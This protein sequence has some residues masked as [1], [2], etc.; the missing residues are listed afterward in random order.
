MKSIATSEIDMRMAHTEA[1]SVSEGINPESLLMGAIQAKVAPEVIRQL[2]DMRGQLQRELAR[3]AYYR[4]FPLMRA[5]I[6]EPEKTKPVY[7]KDKKTVRFRYAPLSS[8]QNAINAAIAKT[9][10][11]FSYR[12][13]C[14]SQDKDSVTIRCILT[15]AFGHSESSE[16][17]NYIDHSAYMNLG[18]KIAACRTFAKRYTVM[19]VNGLE[20]DEDTDNGATLKHTDEPKPKPQLLSV[21]ELNAAKL[22]L[23]QAD[24]IQGAWRRIARQVLDRNDN[25]AHAEL[26]NFTTQLVEQRKTAEANAKA[27]S[28]RPRTEHES[29]PGTR[30][31]LV[32]EDEANKLM[33]RIDQMGMDW[34]WFLR[35]FG[36]EPCIPQDIKAVDYDHYMQTLWE[37]PPNREGTTYISLQQCKALHIALHNARIEPEAFKSYHG[38]SSTKEIPLSEFEAYMDFSGILIDKQENDETP[39]G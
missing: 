36:I 9:G 31:K 22:V 8:I 19:D 17:R 38:I 13:E 33:K 25:A 37:M 28:E 5:A 24:D 34:D 32:T 10:N 4:D 21:E 14:I 26:K 27:H 18:Q 1:K 23:K 16:F 30:P 12:W 39:V 2:L 20:A 29:A 11:K 15:H 35:E 6:V 7:E 3:E